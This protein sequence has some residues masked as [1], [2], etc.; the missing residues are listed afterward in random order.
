VSQIF[1]GD[2]ALA[3]CQEQISLRIKFEDLVQP[4]VCYPDVVF[5][6]DGQSVGHDEGV[7]SP[8]VDHF[9]RLTIQDKDGRRDDKLQLDLLAAPKAFRTVEDKHMSIRIHIHPGNLPEDKITR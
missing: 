8:L 6:V 2:A 5:L 9:P 4:N 1:S 3:Q 7:S